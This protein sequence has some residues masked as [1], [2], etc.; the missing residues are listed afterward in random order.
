M[1]KRNSLLKQIN[2][3]ESGQSIVEYSMISFLIIAG[4]VVGLPVLV[5]SIIAAYDVYIGS[6]YFILSL[7]I[8]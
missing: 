4:G 5:N 1:K 8:L 6:L 2:S 7:P 3:D